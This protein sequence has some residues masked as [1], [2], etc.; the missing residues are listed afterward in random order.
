[1][2]EVIARSLHRP[3][4]HTRVS[5]AG[6]ISHKL[7]ALGQVVSERCSYTLHPLQGSNNYWHLTFIRSKLSS[8]YIINVFSAWRFYVSFHDFSSIDAHVVQ[9]HHR[10][11][12]PHGLMENST[13]VRNIRLHVSNVTPSNHSSLAL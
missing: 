5:K 10:L 11:T 6:L 1:M 7:H 2:F 4:P 3:H 12:D 8:K 13:C 9:L